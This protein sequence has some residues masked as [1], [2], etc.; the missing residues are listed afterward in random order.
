MRGFLVYK[1]PRIE[2]DLEQKMWPDSWFNKKQVKSN[3]LRCI[4]QDEVK[5]RIYFES[6][7]AAMATQCD[8]SATVMDPTPA[9]PRMD[10]IFGRI[11]FPTLKEGNNKILHPTY[12]G[13]ANHLEGINPELTN[14]V[15]FWKRPGTMKRS[16]G[17]FFS[18]TT[19]LP[20]TNDPCGTTIENFESFDEGGAYAVDW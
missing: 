4:M 18:N 7:S 6:M 1:S 10:G 15:T 20:E 3:R 17:T 19:L 11:E 8:I 5:R 12:G 14:V 13:K 16:V 9:S 2:V